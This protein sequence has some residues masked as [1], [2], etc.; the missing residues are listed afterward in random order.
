M[1]F[2]PQKPKSTSTHSFTRHNHDFLTMLTL[3]FR[4]ILSQKKACVYFQFLTVDVTT[5]IYIIVIE[6]N[7]KQSICI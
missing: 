4:D 3:E 7:K 2:L 6:Q 5:C 1:R